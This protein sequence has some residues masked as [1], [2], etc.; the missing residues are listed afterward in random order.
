MKTNTHLLS[1]TSPCAQLI[2]RKFEDRI[3]GDVNYSAFIQAVDEEYI[4]QVVEM[5]GGAEKGGGR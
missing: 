3:G 5:E 2:V 1:H 4:G